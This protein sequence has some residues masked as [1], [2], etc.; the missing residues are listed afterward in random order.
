[1][2]HNISSRPGNYTGEIGVLAAVSILAGDI[3]AVTAA[4]YLTKP[5]STSATDGERV[6]GR[7]AA[8]ADNSAGANGAL[9]IP[10][11]RGVFVVPVSATNA[12]TIADIGGPVYMEDEGNVA[13]QANQE[14]V[15]G[16]LLGFDSDGNAI[17][18]MRA[19]MPLGGATVFASGIH[20]WAG[21]AATTDS[22]AVTGLEATDIVLVSLSAIGGSET[23]VAGVNDAGNDQVDLT[24]DANGTDDD[25]Q[26]SYLVLRPA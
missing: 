15:A 1:M 25:T 19:A 2:A 14:A 8:D 10:V 11:E 5:D 16:I 22:I 12:P 3:V 18:D 4:G 21:G 20:A 9:S 17:V 7:A 13:T 6:L 23:S 24:L 26:V